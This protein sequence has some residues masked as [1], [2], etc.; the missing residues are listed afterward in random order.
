[1]ICSYKN[2]YKGECLFLGKQRCYK[3]YH[4]VTDCYNRI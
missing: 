3:L 2:G 4:E 1:M